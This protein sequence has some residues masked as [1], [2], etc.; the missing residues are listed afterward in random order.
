MSPRLRWTLLLGAL[1][2]TAWLALGDQQTPTIEVV[3]VSEPTRARP[4]SPR[5]EPEIL[6]LAPRTPEVGGKVLFA[7]TSWTPP[8]PKPPPPPPPAPP[9]APPLPFKYVGKQR[10]AGG[11]EVFINQGEQVLVVRAGQSI[12][13]V[14]RVESVKPPT[15]VLTYLP[16]DQTQSMSIGEAE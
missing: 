15:M 9:T 16:L 1:A 12:D 4:S 7:A 2:V 10:I 5:A 8:P 6:A 14:Y 13:Q 3:G 11:W